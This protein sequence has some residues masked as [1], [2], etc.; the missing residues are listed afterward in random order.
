MEK[1]ATVHERPSVSDFDN[2][3]QRSNVRY[4]FD[5]SPEKVSGLAK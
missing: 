3:E 5:S 4:P 2:G 1:P